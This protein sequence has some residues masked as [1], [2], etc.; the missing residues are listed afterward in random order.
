MDA[1]MKTARQEPGRQIYDRSYLIGLLRT[2]QSVLNQD[3]KK[4][5]AL[6]QLSF[7]EQEKLLLDQARRDNEDKQ[8]IEFEMQLKEKVKVWAA[9]CHMRG[10]PTWLRIRVVNRSTTR[11]R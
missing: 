5:T 3:P 1:F 10:T 6:V 2:K 4:A 7:S 11:T 9:A 8:N